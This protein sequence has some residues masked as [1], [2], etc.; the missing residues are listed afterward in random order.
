[1]KLRSALLATFFLS[2]SAFAADSITVD[3]TNLQT[4]EAVGS[5]TISK[6]PF[7]TVFT[8]DLQNLP[9][10]SHG[11]HVH[12]IASC[13]PKKKDGEMVPGGAAGSHYD[14]SNTGSHAAP[15]DFHGHAGDL[16]A[17]HVDENGHATQPVLAPKLMIKELYNRSLMIHVNGDN[18]SDHP[19]PLGGGGAR[20]ACG[21]IK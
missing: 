9:T 1:M 16:P 19:K 13:G 3:M 21:V 7:G 5:V 6:H 12:E 20:L 17:L 10:G 11:F 15:W 18:Y 8:P 4:G 14:P 2:S